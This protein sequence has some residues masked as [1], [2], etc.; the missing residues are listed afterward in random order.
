M[1][2]QY[3]H[4]V[5]TDVS[6]WYWEAHANVCG[7]QAILKMV[8]PSMPGAGLGY[9]VLSPL[10]LSLPQPYRAPPM[11][12]QKEEVEPQAACMRASPLMSACC[13]SLNASLTAG[14][15]A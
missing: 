14:W 7:P 12:A 2:S 10:A 1:Q 9:I 4:Q 11:P 15:L 5:M 13:R 8:Q 3:P 6:F